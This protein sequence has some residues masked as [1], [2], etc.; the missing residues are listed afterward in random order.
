MIARYVHYMENCWL[1][2]G[3]MQNLSM[4]SWK[5]Y[6]HRTHHCIYYIKTY[7]VWLEDCLQMELALHF[8]LCLFTSTCADANTTVMWWCIL[9]NQ[10]LNL[11]SVCENWR[12]PSVSHHEQIP[13]MRFTCPNCA[14]YDTLNYTSLYIFCGLFCHMTARILSMKSYVSLETPSS[15]DHIF[16]IQ[17]VNVH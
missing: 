17:T 7:K 8:T 2:Y 16:S 5:H 12:C 13:K 15:Y 14:Y 1:H 9:P 10:T 3:W 6:T 11:S 4:H